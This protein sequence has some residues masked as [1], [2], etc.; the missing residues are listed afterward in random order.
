MKIPQYETEL[1]E[2]LKIVEGKNSFLEIGSRD[3]YTLG[4]VAEVLAPGARIVSVD[5]PA[6]PWGRNDSQ[7]KLLKLTSKLVDQ[8]FDIH[9]F[10]GNSLDPKIQKDIKKLGPFDAMLIDGDHRYD[11]VKSDWEFYRNL[12]DIVFFHDIDA[13]LTKTPFGHE[14][15]VPVLWNEIKNDFKHKE[16]IAD[17]IPK[18]GIGVIYQ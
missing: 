5:L 15:G 11:G 14:M 9:L 6:G 16:F 7:D 3:G 18:L 12:G 2:L 17:K 10:L 8:G 4:R 1:V 13:A